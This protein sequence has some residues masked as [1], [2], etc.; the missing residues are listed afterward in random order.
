MGYS[1][2]QTNTLSLLRLKL[3]PKISCFGLDF[4]MKTIDFD[5]SFRITSHAGN[6][7]TSFVETRQTILRDQ[8]A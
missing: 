5:D 8:G 7:M 6:P 3:Q 2:H 4:T 1:T